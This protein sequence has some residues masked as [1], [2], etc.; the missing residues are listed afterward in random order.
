MHNIINVRQAFLIILGALLGLALVVPLAAFA[1]ET[2]ASAEPEAEVIVPQASVL[3]SYVIVDGNTVKLGDIF[4]PA[5]PNAEHTVA[6]APKPGQRAVFDSAWVSQVARAYRLNW[7]PTSQSTRV[8]VERAANLVDNDTLRAMLL[9]SLAA[10]GADPDARVVLGNAN[11][12]LYMPTGIDPQLS[13]KQ[14]THDPLS[15][16]FNASLSWVGATG[17]ETIRLSGRLEAMSEVPVLSKRV[18]RGDTIRSD[19]IQWLTLPT[20]RLQRSVVLEV[21]DLIGKSAKRTLAANRPV[22]A[23]DVRRPLLVNKGSSVTMVLQTPLMQLTVKGRA[24]EAGSRG[25]II[26]ISNVQ[27]NTVIEAEITGA[28]MARVDAPA[29]LAMK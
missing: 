6:Y 2:K 3:N 26:R 24:L 23:T 15:G 21:G 7:R 28:G 27:T 25:D 19:N 8:V 17:G 18:M 5:G 14:V 11:L 9:E 12:R 20:A 4:T 22:R 10:K 29:N 1:K 13:V 16:R